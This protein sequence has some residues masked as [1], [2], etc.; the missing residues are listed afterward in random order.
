MDKDKTVKPIVKVLTEYSDHTAVPSTLGYDYQFYYFVYRALRLND[1]ITEL[2]FEKIDDVVEEQGDNITLYQL[3]HTIGTR[4]N[5]EIELISPRDNDLWKTLTVWLQFIKANTTEESQRTYINNTRFVLVTNKDGSRNKL[6]SAI[7]LYQEDDNFESVKMVLTRLY[8]ET[9]DKSKDGK[10]KEVDNPKK[11]QIGDFKDYPLVC[12]FCKKIEV[13]D[14]FDDVIQ[15][16]KDEI[17]YSSV[18]KSRIE[19]VFHSLVGMLHSDRYLKMKAGVPV[20]FT[21][22]SF[23]QNT[24][25]CFEKNRDDKLVF[26]Y[27]YDAFNGDP[28]SLNFIHELI[29]IDYV[30]AKDLRKIMEYTHNWICFK[31]NISDL[32][33]ASDIAPEDE[34]DVYKEAYFD[35]DNEHQHSKDDV[36][37]TDEESIKKIARREVHECRKSNLTLSTTPM[38]KALSNGCFYQLSEIDR[39]GWRADWTPK[40]SQDGQNI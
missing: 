36:D 17:E 12:E 26:R 19:K 7:R 23:R 20:V 38:G 37:M 30:Q 33:A 39:I 31:N 4:K 24:L 5:D 25:A 32:I 40:E 9:L 18:R 15:K 14:S 28:L 8:T 29:Q 16:I 35:W 1:D 34:D 22:E 27:D 13:I 21:R 11:R 2:S 10:G 3:K 6:L